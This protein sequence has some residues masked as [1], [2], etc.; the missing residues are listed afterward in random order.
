MA[1]IIKYKKEKLE[2]VNQIKIFVAVNKNDLWFCRICIASIRYFYSDIE[3]YLIKDDLNGTFSTKEIEDFW[4]VKTVNLGPS[5]FGWSAAKMFLYTDERY[6]GQ[7][8][9][10]MDS[11][12]VFMG[13]VLDIFLDLQSEYD[14]VVSAETQ[15]DP[16]A[17][18]VKQVY[19]DV[20]EVEK[21]D[22]R[23]RYP[24]YFFNAG[25][26]LVKGCFIKKEDIKD[27]FS[28]DFFPYWQKQETFPLVD[29]S[30]LNYILPVLQNE[31]KIKV[32]SSFEYMIWSQHKIAKEKSIS[33]LQNGL[34]SPFLIHWAGD[35][36]THF[37]SKMTNADLL[38]FFEKYYY[39]KI[40]Y[41]IFLFWKRK[42]IPISIWHLKSFKKT[43]K[44]L[45]FSK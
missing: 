29:Q 34:S 11:D 27:N 15:G 36:R 38:L 45:F 5:K 43:I 1:S 3:I 2:D 30:L 6:M 31:N 9:F 28:F 24:G 37:I 26:L 41:G 44:I 25:Q 42:I 8:L 19:F 10:V 39:S 33:F 35:V 23:Y 4:N 32:N 13:K 12:I 22:V 7:Y 17:Q 18:W 21:Y 40:R 20:K 16:Y 14:V